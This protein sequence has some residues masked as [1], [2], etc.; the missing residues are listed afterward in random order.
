MSGR[1]LQTNFK[2]N[3][4]RADYEQAAA[5]VASPI[6]GVAGLRWKIWTVN[7]AESEAGAIY[8]FDDEASLKAYLDGPI[9]AELASHPAFSDLSAKQFEVMEEQT[10]ITRGP[11]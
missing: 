4:P 6:A 10:A 9:V 2:F 3:L 11:V 8:L 1:I 7:E 5:S